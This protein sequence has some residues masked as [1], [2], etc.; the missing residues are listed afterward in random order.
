M[1]PA[2]DPKILAPLCRLPLAGLA[3]LVASACTGM[4]AP[5]NSSAPGAPTSSGGG[6]SGS[7]GASAG[8]ATGAGA[9]ATGGAAPTG[10]LSTGGVKLRL[11]TQAEYL[12]SIQSLLGTLKTQL[13][14]PDDLSVAGFVSVGAA[15]IAV[16]DLAVEQYETA[17]L[18]ATA[19]VFGDTQRWQTLV[20]CQPKADLSDACVTTFIKSFGRL[21]FRRDLVDAEVT[22]WVGVAQS[23]AQLAGTAAQGLEAA[24]SGLLESPNF[25]YRVETNTLDPSNGRLKYDGLSMASR[26]VVPLHRWT[27][28]RRAADLGGCGPARHS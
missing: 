16:S 26:L 19:E 7:A 6:G 10:P 13:T 4:V 2:V 18:A 8:A 28:E 27:A 12:T 21:A 11:L 9:G 23:S 22:Q 14:L 15:E 3:L 25:L 20:G 17:S 5:D 24:T 1:S